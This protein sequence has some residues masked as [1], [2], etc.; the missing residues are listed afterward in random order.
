MAAEEPR[1]GP[2]LVYCVDDA[3]VDNLKWVTP[4]ALLFHAPIIILLLV[5]GGFVEWVLAH[6]GS[7][8]DWIYVVLS[9]SEMFCMPFA[10]PLGFPHGHVPD[11]E[12]ILRCCGREDRAA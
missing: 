2:K 3:D 12:S 7:H 10:E 4:G 8:A 6:D 11:A 5:L 9:A 1:R